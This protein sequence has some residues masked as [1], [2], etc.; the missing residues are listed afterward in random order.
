MT[1]QPRQVLPS[2]HSYSVGVPGKST[3]AA[4]Y[5][6]R[7]YPSQPFDASLVRTFAW[8]GAVMGRWPF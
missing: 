1:D 5:P 6:A 7:T 2:A 4:E 8:F 3:F